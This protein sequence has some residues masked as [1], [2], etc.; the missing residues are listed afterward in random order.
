MSR[1]PKVPEFIGA[2]K[3]IYKIDIDGKI[4]VVKK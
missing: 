3:Y 4:T 2:G 1:Q